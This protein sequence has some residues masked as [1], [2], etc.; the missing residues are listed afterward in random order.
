MFNDVRVAEMMRNFGI[1]C[2]YESVFRNHRALFGERLERRTLSEAEQVLA[3]QDRTGQE[4]ILVH[5]TVPKEGGGQLGLRL[6]VLSLLQDVRF[7][8]VTIKFNEDNDL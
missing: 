1:W 7:P 2:F 3:G 6:L 5:N 4:R 8:R